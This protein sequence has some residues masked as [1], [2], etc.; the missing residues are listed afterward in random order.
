VNSNG[1]SKDTAASFDVTRSFRGF[2]PF[3][4]QLWLTAVLLIFIAIRVLASGTFQNLLHK[5]ARR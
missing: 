2:F 1:G 5:W 3:I 4:V